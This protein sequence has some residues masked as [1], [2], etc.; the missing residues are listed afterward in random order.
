MSIPSRTHIKPTG[1]FAPLERSTG[2]LTPPS[3]DRSRNVT[4]LA[5]W[6]RAA[7]GW[8]KMTLQALRRSWHNSRVTPMP[9]EL[10]TKTIAF[11]TPADFEFC[12]ASK[13]DFPVLKIDELMARPAGELQ[14]TAVQIRQVEK[15]FAEVLQQAI[16]APDSIGELLRNLDIKLFSQDHCW[17][18]IMEALNFLSSEFDVY[19]KLALV[20][21][22]QYLASRQNVVKSIFLNKQ[23]QKPEA[24][25]SDVGLDQGERTQIALKETAIFDLAQL[26]QEA[27]VASRPEL[28]RIPRGESIS[29][30]LHAGEDLDIALGQHR[31]RLEPGELFCLVDINGTRYPLHHGRNMVGRHQN[32]DVVIDAAFSAVSRKHIIIEP[33]G[34]QAVLLTDISA[35][36]SAIAAEYLH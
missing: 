30:H 23:A 13:T 17:R 9:L 19:K 25:P 1:L 26:S 11:N 2:N 28:H 31:F 15:R 20:K 12:L 27:V 29:V 10:P 34:E 7:L 4:G 24:L 21:Y 22:M 5:G 14:R 3:K 18:E 16:D 6:S 33:L 36:G 8:P 35:H 32:N